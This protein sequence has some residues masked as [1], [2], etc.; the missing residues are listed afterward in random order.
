MN[1][2]GSVG[3]DGQKR[4]IDRPESLPSPANSNLVWD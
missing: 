1:Q 3:A 2:R 4:E